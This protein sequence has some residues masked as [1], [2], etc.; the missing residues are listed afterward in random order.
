MQEQSNSKDNKVEGRRRLA[1]D[2]EGVRRRRKSTALPL[3]SKS[4]Y[5][6]L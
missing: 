2:R 5:V 3:R 6:T 1:V 4:L